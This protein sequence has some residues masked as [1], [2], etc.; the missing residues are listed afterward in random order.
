MAVNVLFVCTDNATRGP[1][2]QALLAKFGAGR[3]RAFSAAIRPGPSIHPMAQ[4]I[5]SSYGVNLAED[6]LKPVAEFFEPTARKMDVVIALTDEAERI[7]Q[8]W[9]GPVF[10]ARWRIT[11]PLGESN[12]VLEWKKIRRV[13]NELET[14]VRLLIL[15]RHRPRPDRKTG[16]LSEV[17]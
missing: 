15:V 2:A 14:R 17:A 16:E 5:L 7:V 1:M 6:G 10:K 11:D 4:E 3:F 12:Q 13:F 8:K 9:P